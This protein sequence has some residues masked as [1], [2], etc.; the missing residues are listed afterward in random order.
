MP[1]VNTNRIIVTDDESLI[2]AL[3]ADSE[4]ILLQRIVDKD[5]LPTAE[6]W[7]V[8]HDSPALK[9]PGPGL[10]VGEKSA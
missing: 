5:G 8:P 10:R 6:E 7:L 4:A 9:T 1:L 2:E 3:W